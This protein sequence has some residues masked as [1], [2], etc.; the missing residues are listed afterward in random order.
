VTPEQG[1]IFGFWATV[2]GVAVAIITLTVVIGQVVLMRRQQKTM[3]RQLEIMRKQDELLARRSELRVLAVPGERLI[4]FR[5]ENVGSRGASEYYWHMFIDMRIISN[6]AVRE[7]SGHGQYGPPHEEVSIGGNTYRRYAGLVRD[8]LFPGRDAYIATVTF[9]TENLAGM[10]P[11]YWRL[12]SEDGVFPRGEDYGVV[13]L[14][15]GNLKILRCGL[16]P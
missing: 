2:G 3:D 7:L 5:A 16:E 13:E 4:R 8:P 10:P 15:S 6:H 1:A 14:G 9:G 11:I 12:S